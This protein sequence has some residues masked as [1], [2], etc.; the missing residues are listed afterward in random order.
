MTRFSSLYQWLINDTMILSTPITVRGNQRIQLIRLKVKPE[1]KQFSLT[2]IRIQTSNGAS[3]I[4]LYITSPISSVVGDL[5]RAVSRCRVCNRSRTARYSSHVLWDMGFDGAFQL[6]VDLWSSP[7]GHP[8]PRLRQ[9]CKIG[10]RGI[11]SNM[12]GRSNSCTPSNANAPNGARERYIRNIFSFLLN[13]NAYFVKNGYTETPF[14]FTVL[15][16]FYCNFRKIKFLVK[17]RCDA[18]FCFLG[19]Y[20]RIKNTPRS[21]NFDIKIQTVTI[22]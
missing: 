9:C 11:N 6:P 13:I 2:S 22:L 5:P 21:N 17:Y 20:L 1:I 10:N 4:S 14:W 3:K 8:L 7:L 19:K 12:W 16:Y 18:I 15:K